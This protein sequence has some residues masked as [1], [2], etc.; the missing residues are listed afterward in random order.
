MKQRGPRK[1]F[2]YISHINTNSPIWFLLYR[3]ENCND[4]ISSETYLQS[5]K[6][7]RDSQ[8]DYPF[9]QKNLILSGDSVLLKC[10]LVQR[11]F[12]FFIYS[13]CDI[14]NKR[15]RNRSESRL[16]SQNIRS[17]GSCDYSQKS[18]TIFILWH[19]YLK[20]FTKQ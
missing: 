15:R 3:V 13:K 4:D 16:F 8:L 18:V 12:F 5:S 20:P 10:I 6:T 19:Q 14:V 11:K 17:E 2:V 1:N 7:S 9:F